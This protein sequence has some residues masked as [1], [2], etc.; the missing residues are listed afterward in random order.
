MFKRL[1]QNTQDE[2]NNES[3]YKQRKRRKSP[4]GHILGDVL[5]VAPEVAD[6]LGRKEVKVEAVWI[7]PDKYMIADYD[8]G[9]SV[10][11][12]SIVEVKDD[13]VVYEVKFWVDDKCYYELI[14]DR[15]VTGRVN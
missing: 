12:G 7:S 11:E 3:R 2:S 10:D 5:T 14:G 1:N 6:E 13:E 9:I 8:G 15:A 4:T